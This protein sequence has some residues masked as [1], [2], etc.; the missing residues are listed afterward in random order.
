MFQ[1]VAWVRPR[2]LKP[3]LV[4]R[5]YP[6]GLQQKL[7]HVFPDRGVQ[8]IGPDLFVPAQALTAEAIGI[9]ARAAVVGVGNLA[10]GR[11]STHSF[12][13][14]TVSAPFA[15]NQALQEVTAATGPVATASPVL[16]E[17]SLN[18][19]EEFF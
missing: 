10:L 7:T 2:S 16:L 4:L 6:V 3:P 14:A 18:G 17:L 15:D 19:P 1:L 13:V 11:A 12:A 9:R 5:A 8:D